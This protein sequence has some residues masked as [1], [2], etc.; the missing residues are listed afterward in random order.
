MEKNN[1]ELIETVVAGISEED[2][3]R[4]REEA[5]AKAQ[6]HHWYMQGGWLKCDYCPYPH[7]AFIGNEYVLKGLDNEG[8]PVLDKLK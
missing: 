3:K 2:L 7:G 8:K 5:F 1:E 6:N 4:L